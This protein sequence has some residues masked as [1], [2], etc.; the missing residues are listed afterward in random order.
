[1]NSILSADRN[2]AIGRDNQLL[3][4]ISGDMRRFR[5]LTSGGTVIMGR[6][7]LD[8]LPGGNPLPNRRNLIVTRN[9]D[10]SRQGVEVFHSTEDVLAA[11][12]VDSDDVWV[13]GGGSVYAALLSRCKEVYVTKVDAEI[14]D[15][16]TFFPNLDKLS[17]W[18]AS[19]VSPPESENGL[20]YQYVTY[21]NERL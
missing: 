2:W 5:A 21:R 9:T 14:H 16:D 3:F 20:T 10:F 17:G 4:H 1:M 18:S 13:I 6:K 19:S 11:V 7:T 8:S 12:H 15:A